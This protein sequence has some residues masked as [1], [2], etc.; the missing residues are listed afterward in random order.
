MKIGYADWVVVAWAEDRAALTLLA[1]QASVPLGASEIK[2]T[3]VPKPA[4]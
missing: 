3:E 4:P 2:L 1:N